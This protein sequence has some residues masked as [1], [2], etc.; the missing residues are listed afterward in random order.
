MPFARALLAVLTLMPY[1]AGSQPPAAGTVFAVGYVETQAKAVDTARAA[2]G[3]YR[4]ALER[5]TGCLGVEL[6]A[7]ADRP[8]H[9]AVVE[10][11]RDQA[12]FD[13]RDAAAKR[14][15]MESLA[16]I[17]V[18]DYDERPYKPLT[19]APAK[20]EADARN[21]FVVAHVD[22]APNTQAPMLLQELATASRQEPGNLRFDVLQHAMRGNHFTVIEQWRNQDALD[23]H[24]ATA[25][26]RAY[27]DALQPLTGSPLDERVYAPI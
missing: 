16:S 25:H 11:W 10:T 17:R 23:A 4:Q 6:L 24:V 12:A 2:L 13:G 15:L 1:V 21:T 22:V 3:R 8:G 7:Q 14:G 18:S 26:A 19:L 5:Q 20:T 27:R 9:F